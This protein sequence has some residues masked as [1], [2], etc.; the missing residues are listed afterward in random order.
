M[1]AW[2]GLSIF[3]SLGPFPFNH[4]PYRQHYVLTN[5]AL[6]SLMN[7][8]LSLT[9]HFHLDPSDFPL[10]FSRPFTFNPEDHPIRSFIPH[11]FRPNDHPLCDFRTVTVRPSTF[12]DRSL[13]VTLVPV[14]TRWSMGHGL[15]TL[16][17]GSIKKIKINKSNE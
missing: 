14:Q 13:L 1:E 15:S 16:N 12:A 6:L 10:F 17:L 5:Y 11:R 9:V 3:R 8:L 7:Y 2:F 4:V